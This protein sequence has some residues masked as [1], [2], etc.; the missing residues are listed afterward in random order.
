MKIVREQDILK[1]V[2]MAGA[3]SWTEESL[4]AYQETHGVNYGQAVFVRGVKPN[5]LWSN[6]RYFGKVE[7]VNPPESVKTEMEL[8]NER[9][10]EELA[11]L[12][13][14]PE[15]HTGVERHGLDKRTKEYKQSQA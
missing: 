1:M 4:R 12:K 3:D 6:D 5:R 10:K 15:V 11:S 8:E 9:L 13:E 7:Q 14:K 2:P